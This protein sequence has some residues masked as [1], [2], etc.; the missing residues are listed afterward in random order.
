M[1]DPLARA[2][3]DPGDRASHIGGGDQPVVAADGDEPLAVLRR[4]GGED[5]AGMDARLFRRQPGGA[6]HGAVTRRLRPPSVAEKGGFDDE[7]SEG[8]VLDG[9]R[10]YLPLAHRE[11]LVIHAKYVLYVILSSYKLY[12]ITTIQEQI[13]PKPGRGT[14]FGTENGALVKR[15]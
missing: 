5:R 8:E 2:L 14:M 13:W 9:R 3:G 4:R 6:A 1:V 7:G 11:R 12:S 10:F 15:G